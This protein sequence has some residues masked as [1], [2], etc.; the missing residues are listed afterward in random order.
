MTTSQTS[1]GATNEKLPE[2][3]R[4]GGI[5]AAWAGDD[6]QWW[7]RSEERRVGKECLL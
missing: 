7:D 6:Q 3:N 1:A 5:D 2:A 4:A